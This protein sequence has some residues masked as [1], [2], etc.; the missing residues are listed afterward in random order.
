MRLRRISEKLERDYNARLW[1][2][3]AI[4]FACLLLGTVWFLYIDS[5]E[6]PFKGSEFGFFILLLIFLY[7]L[8]YRSKLIR[9]NAH[10]FIAVKDY[11]YV[12]IDENGITLDS[13]ED[14]IYEE[15][16]FKWSELSKI[17]SHYE[18]I[19]FSKINP[20]QY[21]MG[22]IATAEEVVLPSVYRK[23]YANPIQMHRALKKARKE[24]DPELIAFET[25]P[26]IAV[27]MEF[28]HEMVSEIKKYWNHD[29][30]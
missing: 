2:I 5:T 30:L 7:T 25:G 23:T 20:K 4:C 19:G 8:K 1:I 29:D 6:T 13:D 17:E 24:G 15:R 28:Y 14:G 9:F 18:Q 22:A 12:I 21:R 11:P 16:I 3:R 27:Y 26:R 10:T